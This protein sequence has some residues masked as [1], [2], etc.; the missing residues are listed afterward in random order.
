M[1]TVVKIEIIVATAKFIKAI[2]LINHGWQV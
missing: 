1:L 2:L